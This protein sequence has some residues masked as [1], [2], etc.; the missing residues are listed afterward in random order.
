[1]NVLDLAAILT[2]DSS[3]YDKALG[4]AKANA[5]TLGTSFG[6]VGKMMAAGVAAGGA[7]FAAVS[8]MAVSAYA[9]YEQLEG[10][11]KKLYQGASDELMGYAQQAYQTA[12]MSANQYM[13]QATSFSAALVNSLGGDYSKAAKQ[14]DVAMKAISDN[15]NT[16]GSDMDSVQMAFQGFAKQNYTMLDNLKLGYGGT[17]SEMER[18]IAD[19]NDYAEANGKAADLSIDSFSD[20]ITA[21]QYVQEEQHI[22]GTTANEAATTIEGSINMAKAAWDNL[23]VGFADGNQDI[24]ALAS[25][26]VDSLGTAAKNIVPRFIQ[27]LS[28]IAKGVPMLA[29]KL[30]DAF[31]AQAGKYQSAG[32]EMVKGIAD[33]L[34]KNVTE[35]INTVVPMISKFVENIKA[36]A[37]KIVDAG[38]ELILKLGQ[39][40]VDAIPTIVQYMPTIIGNIAS[41]IIENAPKL[42]E[43]GVKLVA[44]I[45]KGLV[46]ATP[47]IVA[48]VPKIIKAI[49]N[50]F[51]SASWKS[52]G[53]TVIK[54]LVSGIR[55][56]LGLVKSGAKTVAKGGINALK[57]GFSNIKKVGLQV[58][59][60]LARSIVSGINT[61]STAAKSIANSVIDTI[62]G[63]F[64][65]A[66]SIGSNLV[67]GIWNGI[68]GGLG[69]IKGKITG[70]VGDVES[71]FKSLFGISSPSKWARDEIGYNIV[72]GMAEGIE[73]NEDLV[74]SA[75][76]DLVDI[77]DIGSNSIG[78]NSDLFGAARGVSIVNNITVDGAE[79][80]EQFAT[81]FVRQLRIDMRTV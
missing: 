42:I 37:G 36:N 7:A 22:A 23:L 15:V 38:M 66:Y 73:G 28:G 44:M 58:I 40:I 56:A 16:F 9:N 55:G 76:S 47:Q 52:L 69:W 34:S 21:I 18:L 43:T 64:T 8:G 1:M 72:R 70:W 20:I 13:E 39:G 41:L 80:P 60:L 35:I 50:A 65:G 27:A 26:F 11:I 31:V 78:A 29:T 61:V 53:K 79:N 12:G 45:V 49:F 14:T 33:G 68:S 67:S 46:S 30:K 63:I 51:K 2:L 24:E 74:E 19:A 32:L 75:M 6:H 81:R 17:K 71:F 57:N 77:P 62:K 25:T 59:R 10:G 48:A 5:T 54:T 4:D 3:Q